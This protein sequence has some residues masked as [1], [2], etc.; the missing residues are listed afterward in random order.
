MRRMNGERGAVIESEEVR[1]EA[2]EGRK[3]E[4]KEGRKDR[5]KEGIKEKEGF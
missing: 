2:E 1:E 4:R 3:K 5:R